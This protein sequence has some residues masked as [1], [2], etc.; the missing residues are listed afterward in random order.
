MGYQLTMPTAFEQELRRLGLNEWSCAA[1]KE[2]RQW[3]ERN[4]DQYYIPEW[5][6]KEWGMFVDADLASSQ[7][8]ELL[9][10]TRASL[11]IPR[12]A[13]PKAMAS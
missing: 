3:C 10:R 8:P 1:S 5:L 9:T 11:S 6:L 12:S 4:K 13:R 2:L 7:G